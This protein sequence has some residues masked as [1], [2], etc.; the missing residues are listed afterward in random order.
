MGMV[1]IIIGVAWATGGALLYAGQLISI[2]NFPLAQRLG[3]QEKPENADPLASRLELMTARWDLAVLWIPPIAGVLMLMDH[4][5]WP[6]VCLIAGGAYLDA[7]GREW[8][9]I[10]GLR[11]HGVPIGSAR[12]RAAIYAAYAFLIVTGL[13]G[14]VV[15]LAELL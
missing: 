2:V 4:A 3:L 9:K 10:L 6:P 11:A 15:G 5:W 1:Q 13:A 8:A 12:E 14:I 7:G